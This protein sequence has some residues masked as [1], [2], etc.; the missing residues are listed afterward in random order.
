MKRIILFLLFAFLAVRCEA[1]QIKQST[2][3]YPLVFFMADSSDHVTAK[4]GL[5]P[6][7]TISKAGGSFASPSGTVTE[8]ANGWY[9]V[10]GNATDSATL[11]PL[12]LHATGSGA[13]PTDAIY[14]VVAF[15]P[16]DTVRLGLTAMPNVASG[17]SGAL[18][19]DGTG[20]A[21]LSVSGGRGKADVTYWNASAVASPDTAGYPKVTIKDGTGTGELNTSGGYVFSDLTKILGTTL[22]ESSAG[23]L[24][25]NLKTFLD[26]GDNLTAARLDHIT[27]IKTKT[28]YLPS[29]TAGASGGVF[30]A[31]TN[32]QT[33]V[34]SGF[35]ADTI[36][37]TS[38]AANAIGA[39]E[40]ATDAIGE[41][42]I[43][44]SS[45]NAATFVAGAIDSSAMNVTGTEFTSIPWNASWDA[46]VQSE[47]DDALVANHLDHLLAA[48]YDPTSK[49][50]NASA[51]LNVL[52][53]N[54][55]GV[56]R[57]TINAL[58]QGPSGG[59]GGGGADADDFFSFDYSGA[60]GAATPGTLAYDLLNA[61]TLEEAAE[62]IGEEIDLG[63]ASL[64]DINQDPISTARTWVLVQTEQEGLIGDAVKSLRR[65]P[66]TPFAVDFRNDMATNQR[67]RTVDTVEILS[68]TADGISFGDY[69][70]DRTL[71]K[72]AITADTA[73]TYTIKVAVTANDGGEFEGV[74]TLVVP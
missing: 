29:A 53:E 44:D 27:N 51:L 64:T 17:N 47:A 58:E 45:I 24:A 61:P 72:F 59:G 54:D 66:A 18:L 37:A 23:N 43:A 1:Y 19:V 60:T 16:Q 3:A 65:G 49:P 22:A 34:T 62:E 26:N 40:I 28:D 2:T 11:G 10:A 52:V 38:I 42:E 9:K 13:D 71:A 35:G 70:R 73:G 15:D 55:G 33:T 57:F 46:E 21:A 4:T 74:V 50:G 36:T 5:F 32:A 48:A 67:I 31:G 20:T 25:N 14:E 6:T 12:V 30:I 7:V 39:S 8:I 68:G 56:P 63:A 41:T 69:G